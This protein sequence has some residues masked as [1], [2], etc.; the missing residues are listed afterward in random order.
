MERL[1][2]VFLSVQVGTWSVSPF[3]LLCCRVFDFLALVP[4][5]TWMCTCGGPFLEC[6]SAAF[7]TWQEISVFAQGTSK[8][9]LLWRTWCDPFLEDL[10]EV[11][12][13]SCLLSVN[14]GLPLGSMQAEV[15]R[16]S[17]AFWGSRTLLVCGPSRGLEQSMLTFVLAELPFPEGSG[18]WFAKCN[19]TLECLSVRSGPGGCSG[20]MLKCTMGLASLC[21]ADVLVLESRRPLTAVATDPLDVSSCD[22][23]TLDSCIWWEVW[24]ELRADGGSGGIMGD[25]TGLTGDAG[26]VVHGLRGKITKDEQR[27]NGALAF[28]R[29]IGLR[30]GTS[31]SNMLLLLQ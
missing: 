6:T 3:M 25:A 11:G 24:K 16:K 21:S 5:D 18:R 9:K 31:A 20:G 27:R 8:E 12:K 4:W 14:D 28:R 23:S 19:N 30:S 26:G 10:S 29:E 2:V 15:L 13:V 7:E 17:L 22:A 1:T